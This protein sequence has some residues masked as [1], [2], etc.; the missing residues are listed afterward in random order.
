M[1]QM[2]HRPNIAASSVYMDA[3]AITELVSWLPVTRTWIGDDLIHLYWMLSMQR[4]K[5]KHTHTNLRGGN[6]LRDIITLRVCGLSI[7][8]SCVWTS[9]SVSLCVK[10]HCMNMCLQNFYSQR[11][12]FNPTPNLTHSIDGARKAELSI[13]RW[14]VSLVTGGRG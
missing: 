14:A 8:S 13:K 10:L 1:K 7:M 6:C 12:G 4:L 9:R 5:K 2:K 3:E 11:H